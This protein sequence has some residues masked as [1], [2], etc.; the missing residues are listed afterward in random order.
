[1]RKFDKPS[2]MDNL[3]LGVLLVARKL[4]QIVCTQNIVTSVVASDVTAIEYSIFA[5][6]TE[7]HDR[8]IP[9]LEVLNSIIG[10]KHKLSSLRVQVFR[11]ETVSLGK[12][13]PT[14]RRDL[15]TSS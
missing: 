12:W 2:R 14:F 1:M 6:I 3:I 10:P 11:D 13:L 8:M 5:T 7:S 9:I 4:I 15:E